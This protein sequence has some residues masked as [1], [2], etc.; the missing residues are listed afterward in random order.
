MNIELANTILYNK[1][2]ELVMRDMY[3]THKKNRYLT[4]AMTII[5]AVI[6]FGLFFTDQYGYMLICGGIEAIIV[7][8]LLPILIGNMSIDNS[9][10]SKLEKDWTKEHKIKITLKL[11]ELVREELDDAEKQEYIPYKVLLGSV[12]IIALIVNVFQIKFTIL[13]GALIMSL[14]TFLLPIVINVGYY[15]WHGYQNEKYILHL[16][17]EH[18]LDET[19][20]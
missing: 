5:I 16:I 2:R 19:K 1:L 6:Q 4:I 9:I 11:V 12:T 13:S 8:I 7:V 3:K 17:S 20:E 15:I 10:Y 14:L 18:I